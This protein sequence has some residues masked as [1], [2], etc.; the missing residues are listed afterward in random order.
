MR[1]LVFDD[2]TMQAQWVEELDPVPPPPL[3]LHGPVYEPR[4]KPAPD[5]YR[6][7]VAMLAVPTALLAIVVVWN[8]GML[9]RGP[10]VHPADDGIGIDDFPRTPPTWKPT[11]VVEG[12]TDS[13]GR[14]LPPVDAVLHGD[15][16]L[17][18]WR[19]NRDLLMVQRSPGR[20]LTAPEYLAAVQGLVNAIERTQG[21]VPTQVIIRPLE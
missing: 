1:K 3:A 6:F 9:V 14:I 10:G 5:D 4:R 2:T 17:V 7:S 19:G 15:N 18:W 21:Y 16:G 8:A 11:R 13:Q 20:E 12:Y